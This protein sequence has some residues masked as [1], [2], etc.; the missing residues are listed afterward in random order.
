MDAMQLERSGLGELRIIAKAVGVKF[1]SSKTKYN[2]HNRNILIEEIQRVYKLQQQ[3]KKQKELEME[4]EE[5]KPMYLDLEEPKPLYLELEKPL[6]L[7][8]KDLEEPLDLELKKP[9][10]SMFL[11]YTLSTAGLI[12]LAFFARHFYKDSPKVESIPVVVKMQ[13]RQLD[14]LD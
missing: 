11:T 7:E 8:P 2:K 4:L 3:S 12:G 14:T 10:T 1:P 13:Y 9:N 5:P 6:Y